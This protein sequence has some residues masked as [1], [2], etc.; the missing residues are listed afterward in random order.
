MMNEKSS[1]CSVFLLRSTEET[2]TSKRFF[3]NH[4]DH[5]WYRG[6]T[7]E[8][9]HSVISYKIPLTYVKIQ[10][11]GR[12]RPRYILKECSIDVIT[13][14]YQS[15]YILDKF[16]FIPCSIYLDLKLNK[17]RCFCH[18]ALIPKK[19]LQCQL[20]GAFYRH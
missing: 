12:K 13:C 3:L 14:I 1:N 8:C 4:S 11:R 10:S 2:T 19:T 18:G 6:Y 7:Y 9:M 5:L 20:Q 17:W 16:K 15:T